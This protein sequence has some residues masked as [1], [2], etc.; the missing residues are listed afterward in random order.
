MDTESVRSAVRAAWSML[1]TEMILN[2]EKEV[3]H[4][5]NPED[6]TEQTEGKPVPQNNVK[7]R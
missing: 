3:P 6:E 1:D 2:G 5:E 7:G 4:K